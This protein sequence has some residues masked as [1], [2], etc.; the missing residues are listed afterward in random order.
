MEA[1]IA[2]LYSYLN[3]NK[4]VVG[5]RKASIIILALVMILAMIPFAC[6]TQH[7]EEET[8]T[9]EIVPPVEPGEP[10]E[11]IGVELVAEGFTSPLAFVSPEDGTGRMFVVDQAGL[12]WVID[13]EGRVLEE[14]FLDLR[15]EIVEL[16]PGF[17]ERGL[18]GLAFHPNFRQNG[19]FFV[20][21]SA[22]LRV[23][24]PE[25]WNHTAVIAEFGVREDDSNAADPASEEIILQINQP[26]FNHN[27]GHIIFGPDGYLYIPL[28][29]GGGAN[30]VGLGHPDIGNGQDITTL[31]GSILRIDID[32]GNPY[33]IP[34]DNPFVGEEGRDE[35]FAYGLRNPYRSSFDAME[36]NEFFVADV[37]QALWE[38]VNIVT[39]GGNYGWN[40]KEGTHCF[41]PE[42]PEQ[43]PA[44]C[45]SVGAQG[46]P[47]LDPIFEYRN[48]R[49]EGIGI[50]VIGGYVY[51]GEAINDLYGEYI[52]GDWSRVV[53]EG[54]GVVFAA[55]S[56]NEEW[57]F[58][59]LAISNRENQRMGLFITGF[60]QDADNELY[61]LTTENA[62]PS[63]NTG[64]VYKIVPADYEPAEA[65]NIKEKR[66][67]R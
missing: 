18:L 37:G 11:E 61:I 6:A 66:D 28:G 29:D 45:P 35:I 22:P 25:G 31:L 14:Y 19:R 26:H 65:E 59:E 30:D 57:G 39:N 16:N 64:Q 7:M 46:E 40:I 63:G 3:F 10:L 32:Q 8:T 52:F 33:T 2:R 27:G 60:G 20:H 5:V 50:A 54:D 38:E 51:R 12:I 15:G 42:N 13:G 62:G 23:G 47:L 43:P 34:D 41:D 24:A 17:D 21:Y 4:G 9:V 1:M 53:G 36:D 44:E 49:N 56:S 48:A 58:R 67:E 55:S